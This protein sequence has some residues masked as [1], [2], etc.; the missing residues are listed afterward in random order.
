LWMRSR[1]PCPLP[2]PF[3]AVTDPVPTKMIC[4]CTNRQIAGVRTHITGY[5]FGGTVVRMV[6][7]VARFPRACTAP[8][9]AYDV[10]H[11]PHLLPHSRPPTCVAGMKPKF[12]VLVYISCVWGFGRTASFLCSTK[13]WWALSSAFPCS[14]RRCRCCRLLCRH[15]CCVPTCSTCSWSG[16]LAA[17]FR[18]SSCHLPPTR[19]SGPRKTLLITR[20]VCERRGV[21]VQRARD[22]CATRTSPSFHS[23]WVLPSVGTAHP[24][25]VWDSGHCGRVVV[26]D[27]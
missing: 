22:T 9:H 14:L 16:L 20:C 1:Y 13:Q 18:T 21:C 8:P 2:C 19:R 12:Q 4:L 6:V 27:T 26:A 7:G 10:P 3:P 11:S 5:F 24:M 23:V 15:P 25:S 17:L